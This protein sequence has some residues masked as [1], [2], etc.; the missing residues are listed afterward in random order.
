M[1]FYT[2]KEFFKTDFINVFINCQ[3]SY[4]A[5]Q[6]IS[7]KLLTNT[8]KPNKNV[9]WSV[10]GFLVKFSSSKTDEDILELRLFGFRWRLQKVRPPTLF[11]WSER[12]RRE[13]LKS[14]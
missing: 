6:V 4:F 5:F 13:V 10:T 3:K 11:I 12:I 14:L 1:I 2:Y 8:I 9:F 7:N